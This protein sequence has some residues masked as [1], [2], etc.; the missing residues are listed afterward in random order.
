MSL[1]QV[2]GHGLNLQSIAHKLAI[3]SE[4]ANGVGRWRWK[5][6]MFVG[7]HLKDLG[8]G[9]S[10][11]RLFARCSIMQVGLES[12]ESMFEIRTYDGAGPIRFDMSEQDVISEIGQPEM[13][14][15]TRRGDTELR[16][17]KC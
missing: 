2:L 3:S 6:G 5:S 1:L 13:I 4:I 8:I 15:K 12:E 11:I 17:S 9:R 10:I 7:R 14:R 16:Y